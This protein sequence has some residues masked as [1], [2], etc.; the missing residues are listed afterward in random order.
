MKI[1]DTKSNFNLD[2]L[3]K[4]VSN[5][6][7][8]PWAKNSKYYGKVMSDGHIY[9]PYIHRRWL[10]ARYISLLYSKDINIVLNYFYSGTYRINFLLSEIKK[11]SFLEKKDRNAYQERKDFFTVD[12]CKE[13]LIDFIS[14]LRISPSYTLRFFGVYSVQRQGVVIKILDNAVNNIRNAKSYEELDKMASGLKVHL[15]KGDFLSEKFNSCFL[16]AGGYYTIKHAI[17]FENAEYKGEKGQKAIN[18]LR[19]DINSDWK[20]FEK[21]ARELFSI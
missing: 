1:I 11:L 12:C 15:F 13:I 3:R 10:P 20:Y 14:A 2:A 5:T 21:I 8:P 6:S 18:L 4:S 7:N 16:R 19:N 9:N 17:M